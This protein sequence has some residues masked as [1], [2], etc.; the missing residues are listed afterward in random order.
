[1]MASLLALV[2]QAC[3]KIFPYGSDGA[4]SS[5]RDLMAAVVVARSLLR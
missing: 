2:I 5:W 3:P 1:M 4:I